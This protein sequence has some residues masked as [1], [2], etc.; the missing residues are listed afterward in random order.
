MKKLN[1]KQPN[2][3][4]IIIETK[5][6]LRNIICAGT[7]SEELY[8]NYDYS[9]LTDF[10]YL[11]EGCSDLISIPHL[12]TSRIT[13]MENTFSGCTNLKKTPKTKYFECY[14]YN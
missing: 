4:K 11:L 12:D 13:S 6:E 8:F 2:Q 3:P 7:T 9:T 1:S 10:D 14:I 5:K